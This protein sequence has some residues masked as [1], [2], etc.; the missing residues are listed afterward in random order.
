M[1]KHWIIAS[2]GCLGNSPWNMCNVLYVVFNTSEMSASSLHLMLRFFSPRFELGGH[3][4]S[5]LLDAWWWCPVIKLLMVELPV[6]PWH[7]Q[8]ND[9]RGTPGL[10][11]RRLIPPDGWGLMSVL[12]RIR[13]SGREDSAKQSCETR[14]NTSPVFSLRDE[15]HNL[16]EDVKMS[17][18][19]GV[20]SQFAGRSHSD[21]VVSSELRSCFHPKYMSSRFSSFFLFCLSRQW[22]G[23]Q[24][25]AV[26]CSHEPE[27]RL[28]PK[29]VLFFPAAFFT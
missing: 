26:I 2:Y 16:P 11:T 28:L 27:P 7:S 4:V 5:W 22:P 8:A 9:Q 15:Q 29:L 12:A 1:I 23:L 19:S 14:Q 10:A 6:I 24:L 13:V 18:L 25:S 21:A 17:F 3:F 20:L